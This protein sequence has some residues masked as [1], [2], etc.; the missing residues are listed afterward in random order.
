MKTTFKFNF[1]GIAYTYIIA[2]LF[3]AL[4]PSCIN[5]IIEEPSM[6]T[7]TTIENGKEYINLSF[8]I[9]VDPMNNYTTQDF[10]IN[11]YNS[12]NDF[13]EIITGGNISNLFNSTLT[14]TIK[15][16]DIVESCV[17]IGYKGFV[18]G[19]F[20]NGKYVKSAKKWGNSIILNMK[21]DKSLDPSK[22]LLTLLLN[23]DPESNTY[24]LVAHQITDPYFSTSY[25]NLS[26]L[27]THCPYHV[28]HKLS[29]T[30][31]WDD[32][33]TNIILKRL[34]STILILHKDENYGLPN[35]NSTLEWKAFPNFANNIDE[36]LKG[37]GYIE[38]SR[39]NNT[40]TS[41]YYFENLYTPHNEIVYLTPNPSL[42]Y[43]TTI[44]GNKQDKNIYTLT[45]KGENYYMFNPVSMM[46]TS[47]DSFPL[48]DKSKSPINFITLLADYKTI[49]THIFNDNGF[50]EEFYFYTNLNLPENG[51]KRNRIYLYILNNNFNFFEHARRAGNYSPFENSNTEFEESNMNSYQI[52]E[53]NIEDGSVTVIS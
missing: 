24:G 10:S 7:Y 1:V 15:V 9:S 26:N 18:E 41:K 39:S 27:E 53:Y 47:I 40:N 48:K 2:I 4:F 32:V 34:I 28:S 25:S 8:Q 50:D 45:F 37:T 29:A 44:V 51:I 36:Y 33:D 21:F 17:I 6:D 49:D 52:L 11:S 16:N 23:T 20:F 14:M 46:T 38:K 19:E 35:S 30:S 22:I 42:D 31:N 5:S 12:D 13:D 3:M 43:S